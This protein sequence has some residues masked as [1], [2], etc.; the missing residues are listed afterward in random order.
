MHWPILSA[1]NSAMLARLLA[2]LPPEEGHTRGHTGGGHATGSAH[3]TCC[4]LHTAAAGAT[5]GPDPFGPC[6][7]RSPAT[8]S[9]SRP[10]FS[11]QP[12]VFCDAA[13]ATA[14]PPPSAVLRLP[15]HGGGVCRSGSKGP[16][17]PVGTRRRRRA[18][19]R[20]PRHEYWRRVWHR[21]WHRPPQPVRGELRRRE[22]SHPPASTA[23][24]PPPNRA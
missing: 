23:V 3:A 2:V 8:C 6:P 5:A 16:G 17:Q 13:D 12:R 20:A 22:H 7:L 18:Q 14:G 1:T 4:L 11:T 10:R 21:R 19:A 15:R 24:R 9:P